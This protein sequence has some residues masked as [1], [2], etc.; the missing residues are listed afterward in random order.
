MASDNI[1][2]KSVVFNEFVPEGLPELGK[3][4]KIE[5][6]TIDTSALKSGQV[7]FKTVVISVD[8]YMR[9]RMK[10][11]KSYFPGFV[12]GSPG[13]GGVVLK[14]VKSNNDSFKQGEFY[15]GSGQWSEYVVLDLSEKEDAGKFFKVSEHQDIPLTTAVGVLGMPG[16]TAYFGLLDI[17][18]PKEGEVVVVSGAAGAVG[19]I[20]LQIAKIKGC[21]VIGIAGSQAKLDWLKALG[22][23]AG[24]NYKTTDDMSQAIREAAPDG[25]DVYFDNV[26][27]AIKDAVFDNL[28]PRARVSC[29]GAISSYNLKN[30]PL[31]K[32]Q[33]WIIITKQ[34]MVEGFLCNRWFAQWPK[35][36]E[37]MAGWIKEG[38][39][40]FKETKK[41]SIENVVPAFNAMMKGENFGKMLVTL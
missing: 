13:G 38:K 22:A 10:D 2:S 29:C 15:S 4:W 39:L 30:P 37:E 3:H 34:I 36:F 20:V 5:E 25:V 16:A 41:E 23:D 7:L 32:N 1:T 21:K 24:I 18:K 28:N 26:G 33:E 40:T 19:S 6:K 8:P 14:V 27:G 9:G 17:C 11:I 35:A 12:K 31:V